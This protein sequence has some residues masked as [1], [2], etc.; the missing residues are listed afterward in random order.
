MNK[1]V[2]VQSED[3][4]GLFINEKLVE[5]GHTI[6]EGLD[7]AM[8]LN[9]LQQTYDFTL[10]DMDIEYVSEEYQNKLYRQGSFDNSLS[11]ISFI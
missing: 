6:N 3:W 5:E 10:D 8:Y 7:R 2:L 9:K 4:E 11:Q 1:A